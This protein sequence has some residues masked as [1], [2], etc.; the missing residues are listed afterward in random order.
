M[1]TLKDSLDRANRLS[2]KMR[3]SS[4]FQQAQAF[5]TDPA[6]QSAIHRLEQTYAI[7]G[8]SMTELANKLPNADV[9]SRYRRQFPVIA[10]SLPSIADRHKIMA[11]VSASNHVLG[12]VPPQYQSA[13]NI[14]S[15][16]ANA[17]VKS[18]MMATNTLNSQIQSITAMDLRT[19]SQ[20]NTRVNQLGLK[21][22]EK[23]GAELQN[24]TQ[25]FGAET[26]ENVLHSINESTPEVVPSKPVKEFTETQEQNTEV[27]NVN[28]PSNTGKGKNSKTS[29]SIINK[30]LHQ[31]QSLSQIQV[32]MFN[33]A[34]GELFSSLWNYFISNVGPLNAVIMILVLTA[35]YSTGKESNHLN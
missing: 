20:F 24:L 32:I 31:Y 27:G 28:Q 17:P 30:V 25:L 16:F 26:I 21:R 6:K 33:A 15:R 34:M 22:I 9:Y 10:S 14:A 8:N 5:M 11:A 23:T 29:N 3:T 2:A 4:G 1:A 7:H 18:A 19:G 12:G 35:P 13:I